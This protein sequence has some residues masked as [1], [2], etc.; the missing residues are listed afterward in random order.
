MPE[1]HLASLCPQGATIDR[2]NEPNG[3]GTTA[4]IRAASAGNTKTVQVLLSL[5]ANK[6]GVYIMHC[7]HYPPP[8][9]IL[10][11]TQLKTVYSNKHLL[12]LFF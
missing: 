4:L 8:H 12:P 5:G 9:K 3:E 6:V 1:A 7:N 2:T 11:D 10:L